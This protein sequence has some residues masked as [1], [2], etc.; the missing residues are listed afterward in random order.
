MRLDVAALRVGRRIEVDND[1]ALGERLAERVIEF[2]ARE[3]SLGFE[4]GR[5]VA[6]FQRRQRRQSDYGGAQKTE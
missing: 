6:C 1:W 3:R 5:R 4:R 2:L